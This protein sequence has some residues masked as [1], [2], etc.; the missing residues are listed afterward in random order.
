M[1]IQKKKKKDGEKSY[2]KS[3]R[4]CLVGRFCLIPCRASCFALVDLEETVEFIL[5]FQTDRGK[6]AS[7]AKN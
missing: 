6:T 3:R 2:G 7:A 4:S 1:Y 5:F